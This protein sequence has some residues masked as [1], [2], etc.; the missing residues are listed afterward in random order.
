MAWDTPEWEGEH[1]RFKAEEVN[2]GQLAASCFC[3][4]GQA[5][6]PYCGSVS[7]SE[8]NVYLSCPAGMW[9]KAQP[10]F[11]TRCLSDPR[12]RPACYPMMSQVC[13][14]VYQLNFVVK[15]LPQGEYVSETPGAPGR[16]KK[17]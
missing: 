3:S 5:T 13:L 8:I 6:P 12:K 15:Y 14:H 17:E 2:V 7:C 9:W 4:R 11:K 16:R 1:P 10:S